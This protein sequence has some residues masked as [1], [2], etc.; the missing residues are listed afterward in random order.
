M[1]EQ[2]LVSVDEYAKLKGVSKSY[3]YSLMKNVLADRVVKKN[4][5]KFI[6]I[7][8]R[9]EEKKVQQTSNE[10]QQAPAQQMESNE[11]PAKEEEKQTV[12][13]KYKEEIARLQ[14]ELEEERKHSREKDT[15]LLDLMDKVLELTKNTQQL[16]ARVQ[17][18]QVMLQQKDQQQILITDGTEKKSW[19]SRFKRKK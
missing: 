11:E 16:T 13:D 12:E 19:F 1:S 10:Q 2:K 4:G 8:E 14:R 5:T 9:A 18:Q 17:E 3:V 7:A 15:K 6:D